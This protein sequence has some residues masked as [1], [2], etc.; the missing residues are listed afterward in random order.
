MKIDIEIREVLSRVISVNTDS[1][2]EAIDKVQEM[3]DREELVLD[4][5]DF[6]GNVVI[7]KNSNL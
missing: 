6:D 5:T 2:E 3:Y 7:K 4:Y 1:I